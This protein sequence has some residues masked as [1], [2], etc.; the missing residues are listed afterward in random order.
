MVILF[1]QQTQKATLTK[2]TK[3]GQFY[4]HFYEDK[5]GE[6]FVECT[7]QE[8]EALGLKD[9]GAPNVPGKWIQSGCY[10]KFNTPSG[11]IED[12]TYHDDGVRQYVKINGKQG[13]LISGDIV[14]DKIS[15]SDFNTKLWQ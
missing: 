13:V 6:H 7:Q 15:L 1:N 3:L 11:L 9:A 8:Y 12:G 5:T 14:D 4:G 2:L 10:D